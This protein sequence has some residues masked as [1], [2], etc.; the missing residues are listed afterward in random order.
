MAIVSTTIEHMLEAD[1]Q[2][3]IRQTIGDLETFRETVDQFDAYLRFQPAHF[4][5]RD[6]NAQLCALV[7]QEGT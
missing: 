2:T 6:V 1:A 7:Q 3:P 4:S 5:R